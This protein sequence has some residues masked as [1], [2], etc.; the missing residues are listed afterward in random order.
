M[1]QLTVA[2][3]SDKG[4]VRSSNQDV[5]LFWEPDSEDEKRGR[6]SLALICDGVGGMLNGD[7]AAKLA[8]QT[9][10]DAF[11]PLNLGSSF[12]SALWQIISS[13]NVAV[14][15]A[16]MAPDGEGRMQTTCTAVILRNDQIA[17][18]HVGDCRAYHIHRGQAR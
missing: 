2:T 18:G 7:V 4:P 11:K 15:D 12:N 9:A 5:I 1:L 17:V 14:Y 16:G 6:G 10:L 13:A 8:A 3:R